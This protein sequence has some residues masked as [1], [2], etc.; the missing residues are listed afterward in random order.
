MSECLPTTIAALYQCFLV[1]Y[2]PRCIREHAAKKGQANRTVS[3]F[4]Q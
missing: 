2:H 1:Q 4:C 3:S